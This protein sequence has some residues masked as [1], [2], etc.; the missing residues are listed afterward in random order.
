MPVNVE[1]LNHN[2]LYAFLALRSSGRA[3]GK[4]PYLEA[5]NDQ[6]FFIHN[7]GGRFL[8]AEWVDKV[9]IVRTRPPRVSNAKTSATDLATKLHHLTMDFAF[10]DKVLLWQGEI[11]DQARAEAAMISAMRGI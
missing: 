10:H 4:S 11:G 5:S 3:A 8:L 6:L 9:L 1:V 7:K 2:L